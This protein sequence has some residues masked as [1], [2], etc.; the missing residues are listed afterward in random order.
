MQLQTIPTFIIDRSMLKK[1][2][3]LLATRHIVS[4]GDTY[5]TVKMYVRFK[6]EFAYCRLSNHV[7]YSYFV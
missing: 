2:L 4:F 5:D 1:A 7:S 3:T 6:S